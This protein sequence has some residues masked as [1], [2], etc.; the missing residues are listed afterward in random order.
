[1]L[2]YIVHRINRQFS[3]DFLNKIRPMIRRQQLNQLFRRLPFVQR[4]VSSLLDLHLRGV[5]QEYRHKILKHHVDY[6]LEIEVLVL[7]LHPKKLY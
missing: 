2:I 6:I 5:N 3:I 4:K 7:Q 1:M